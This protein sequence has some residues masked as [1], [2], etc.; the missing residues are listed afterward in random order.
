MED[1]FPG[2]QLVQE[3]TAG[4]LED[5]TLVR[6][7]GTWQVSDGAGRKGQHELAV[8]TDVGGPVHHPLAAP[9]LDCPP[10]GGRRT[11]L[12]PAGHLALPGLAHT[13][14]AFRTRASR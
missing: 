6:N 12:A 10:H 7:V 13:A 14:A 9:V 3:V 4:L 2:T 1:V 11:R 5:L 8:L